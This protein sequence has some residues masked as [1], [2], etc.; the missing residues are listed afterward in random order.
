MQFATEELQEFYIEFEESLP[1][2]S[3]FTRT[4]SEAINKHTQN[5]LN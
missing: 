5:D 4:C 3:R 1:S 2:F